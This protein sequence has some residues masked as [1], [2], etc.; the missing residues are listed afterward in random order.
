MP[1]PFVLAIPA[2][3]AA[4]GLAALG[5]F[6]LVP[7]PALD[8]RTEAA[9]SQKMATALVE[10]RPEDFKKGEALPPP[11]GGNWPWFRGP[12]YSAVSS[13]DV[14]LAR[15]WNAEGPKKLWEVPVGIGYGG[16]AIRDGRVY[17]MDH[18]EAQQA[19]VLRCLS[20][21]T[22]HELWRR[23]YTISIDSDHG[24]TRTVP[25][26]GDQFVVSI[27]PKCQVLCCNPKT[28]DLKW[29]LDMTTEFK[30][31]YP[32]WYTGQCPLL[33]F[34]KVI[35]APAGKE[36]LMAALDGATGKVLWKTPNTHGWKMTH[37]SVMPMEKDSWK[38]Y[39]YCA[40]GGVVG[41]SA[42]DGADV[43]AGDILWEFDKW[44]VNFAN[45]PSPVVIGDGRVLLTG[46][47]DSGDTKQQFPSVA[48]LLQLK[49]SEPGSKFKFTAE[50]VWR[51]TRASQFGADQQT[52]IFYGG[53]V[54]G[55]LP[56]SAGPP[57]ADNWSAWT[58]PANTSGRAARSIASAWGLLRGRRPLV[59][60]ER[61]GPTD[62]GRGL[63]RRLQAPGH[64]QGPRRPRNLGADGHQRR[65]APRPWIEPIG[66]PRR[67]ER[68]T[69]WLPTNCRHR[70]S[71]TT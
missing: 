5:Y 37:S 52:P 54:F 6:L 60:D 25:A 41:V 67:S 33:D 39:V 62:D 50:P 28:G 24:I 3:L 2:V 40:S 42:V 70:N 36:V 13:K 59:R 9:G 58:W 38:M 1:K 19:N 15:S 64:R 63:L 49:E 7:T 48:V 10:F 61:R 34:D 31:K 26:V 68:V 69:P 44:R 4:L 65:P 27:G 22:G 16:P 12:D 47:Y 66:L 71:S 45:V 53:A 8:E 23:W 14:P 43:K 55:V 21:A 51:M 32:K 35:L 17:L 29:G 11:F 57:W 20:L 18:D 46:G 30:T 56:M